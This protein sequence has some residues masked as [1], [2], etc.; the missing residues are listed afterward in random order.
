MG[1]TSINGGTGTVLGTLFG[2]WMIY[3]IT[4]SLI[5]M[6]IP[7][8]W[9]SV[10]IGFILILSIGVNAYQKSLRKVEVKIIES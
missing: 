1:G 6:G 3:M 8:E 7:S 10:V 4:N 9:E 5:L 2:V